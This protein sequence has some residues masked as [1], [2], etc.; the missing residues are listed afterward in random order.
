MEILASTTDRTHIEVD[1]GILSKEGAII[2]EDTYYLVLKA[3]LLPWYMRLGSS[4][5]LIEL[6]AKMGEKFPMFN[7]FIHYCINIYNYYLPQAPDAMY[8]NETLVYSKILSTLNDDD[9]EK[10]KCYG[11][12]F[13]PIK[14]QYFILIEDLTLHNVEFPTALDTLS[15]QHQAIA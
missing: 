10:P 14:C 1:F 11:T 7:Q 5:P 12:V 13:N 8:I 3:V 4:I 15:I 2:D 9:I 6:C